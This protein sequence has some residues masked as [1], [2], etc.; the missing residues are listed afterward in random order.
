MSR[1]TASHNIACTVNALSP[2]DSPPLR[3]TDV[4]NL[5]VLKAQTVPSDPQPLAP[6]VGHV[7]ISRLPLHGRGQTNEI[8]RQSKH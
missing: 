4:R 2:T 8:T 3:N 1:F 7:I 5:D 6:C